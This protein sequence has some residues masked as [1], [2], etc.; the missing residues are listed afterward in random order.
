MTREED[1]KR[2][3]PPWDDAEGAKAGDRGAVF[4]GGGEP[5]FLPQDSFAPFRSEP[6]DGRFR[7]VC[8]TRML[9]N[10]R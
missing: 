7:V 3:R 9:R 10:P 4:L 8:G 1:P 2:D 5:N 6:T